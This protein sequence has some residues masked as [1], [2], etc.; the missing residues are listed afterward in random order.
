[1]SIRIKIDKVKPLKITLS[2]GEHKSEIDILDN[3]LKIIFE[4][5]EDLDDD[6]FKERVVEKIT[7]EF[8]KYSKMDEKQINDIW[9]KYSKK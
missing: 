1:M 9:E 4:S 2:D 8:E 7:E 6:E 3:P 5:D